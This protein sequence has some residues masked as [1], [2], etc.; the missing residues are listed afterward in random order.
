MDFEKY[1]PKLAKDELSTRDWLTPELLTEIQE[2]APKPSDIDEKNLNARDKDAFSVALQKLFPVGRTFASPQQIGNVAEKFAKL[3]AFEINK[4][5]NT[6]Q[7]YFAEPTYKKRGKGIRNVQDSIKMKIKCPFRINYKQNKK[8]RTSRMRT[9][10]IEDIPYKVY[11]NATITSLNTTH[12]CCLNTESHRIA[13]QNNGSF[14][15]NPDHFA[16]IIKDVRENMSMKPT[17]LREKLK[18][19]VPHYILTKKM[20]IHNFKKRILKRFVYNFDNTAITV[21]ECR[22]LLNPKLSA[23]DEITINDCPLRYKNM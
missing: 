7:C 4:P 10:S 15:I 18:F 13:L 14:D 9:T 19:L 8:K 12:T 6:I 21:Q 20:F 3:W 2:C 16:A 17:K 5:G 23:A 11:Y 1:P 22:A